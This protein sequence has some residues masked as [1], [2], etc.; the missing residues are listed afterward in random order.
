MKYFIFIISLVISNLSYSYENNQLLLHN[1][2]KKI[3]FFDL[4]TLDGKK[5]EIADK[6]INKTMTCIVQKI[7]DDRILVTIDENTKGFVKKT[8]LSKN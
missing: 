8:N 3:N 2:A 6:L 7:N 5:V 1:P 4:R